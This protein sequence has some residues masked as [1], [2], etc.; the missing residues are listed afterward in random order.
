[1]MIQLIKIKIVQKNINN[2]TIVWD[3]NYKK[4]SAKYNCYNKLF[5]NSKID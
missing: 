5:V 4:R 2:Y 1:M 3:K